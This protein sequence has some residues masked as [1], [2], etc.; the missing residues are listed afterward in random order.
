MADPL[1]D[2]LLDRIARSSRSGMRLGSVT[3][4]DVDD[5]SLTLS[6][7]GD[8]IPGVRW[9]GSYTPVELDVVVVS[10]VGAMWVVLGKLS[11]QYP[12]VPTTLYASV[13][14]RP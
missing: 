6:L 8:V 5:A 11:K 10:R 7:A 3:T 9:I 1:L 12:V 2:P 14:V 4:I 13:T